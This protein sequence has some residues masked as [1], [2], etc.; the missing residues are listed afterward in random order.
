MDALI[1][2]LVIMR[3]YANPAISINCTHDLLYVQVDPALVSPE[4]LARLEELYF[5]PDED[6]TG[7][8]SSFL[9]SC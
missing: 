3:K 4:D 8:V 5:D 1:E 6:G 9:G 2:A 7:F